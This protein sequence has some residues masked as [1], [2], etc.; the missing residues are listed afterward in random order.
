MAECPYCQYSLSDPPERFCPSCGRDLASGSAASLPAPEGPGEGGGSPWER[1]GTIGVVAGLTETT[2][3]VLT[4]PEAFFRGLPA[5]A[6][7]GDPLFYAV[8]VGYIGLVAASVYNAVFNAT[9]GSAFSTLGDRPEFARLMPLLHG[10]M[11][12]ALN[13]ILGPFLIVAGLFI[14]AGILH[15]LLLLLGGGARGFEATFRAI[16]YASASNLFQ[17]IPLC[18]GLVGAVYGIV[19]MIIGL[20][21]AHDDSKGK[22]AAAVL[23]PLVL[24]CCCCFAG[25]ALMAGGIAS[26]ASQVR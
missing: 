25:I 9:F 14:W 8:I 12:L 21:A 26:L 11:G 6:S 13:L 15:L 4:A 22:A 23:I 5:R 17:I 7:I 18:G 1:R 2:Q 10:G 19:L 20:S 16:A 24:C 3:Q